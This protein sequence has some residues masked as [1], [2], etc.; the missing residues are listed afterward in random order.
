MHRCV[1]S[2]HGGISQ[3]LYFGG[4]V[5]RSLLSQPAAIERSPARV[6]TAAPDDV[7]TAAGGAYPVGTLRSSEP[8]RAVEAPE[9]AKLPEE[10]RAGLLVNLAG[11]CLDC[12]RD[13]QEHNC[14]FELYCRFER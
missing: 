7:D 4:A 5:M 9:R 1:A 13:P 8:A 10:R 2:A 3:R 11:T 6:L 12:A 14:R